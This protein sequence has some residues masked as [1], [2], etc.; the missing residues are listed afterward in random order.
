MESIA[1]LTLQRRYLL[2]TPKPKGVRG[3]SSDN[4]L[5]QQR[6]G[7]QP[8]VSL[9]EGLEVTYDWVRSR[10]ADRSGAVA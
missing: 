7:W 6:Y 3:R 4:A 2:D 10:V 1:G 9:R 5:I 8:G